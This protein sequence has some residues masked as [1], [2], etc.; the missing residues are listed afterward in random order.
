MAPFAALTRRGDRPTVTAPAERA[1][2][3]PR[4]QWPD[5]VGGSTAIEGRRWSFYTDRQCILCSVCTDVAPR[6]FRRSGEP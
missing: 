5:N 2:A 1:V 6:N 4:D 3:D